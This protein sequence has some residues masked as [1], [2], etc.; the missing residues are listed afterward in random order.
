MSVQLSHHLNTLVL[1]QVSPSDCPGT[2]QWKMAYTQ[3]GA[4]FISER[5]RLDMSATPRKER[6]GEKER[7]GNKERKERK[8]F[9]MDSRKD[10]KFRVLLFDFSDTEK[11]KASCPYSTLWFAYSQ[12]RKGR[13]KQAYCSQKALLWIHRPHPRFLLPSIGDSSF[14]SRRNM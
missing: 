14:I 8:Q 11:G 2:W 4:P 9:T 13:Q 6:K 5:T 10:A 1:H 3:D 12:P 7:K